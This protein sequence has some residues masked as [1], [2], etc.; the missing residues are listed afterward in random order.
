MSAS[1]SGSNTF[2][3]RALVLAWK[4]AYP[5]GSAVVMDDMTPDPHPIVNGTRGALENVDGAGQFH[6][7]WEG[8]RSLAAIPGA[9]KFRVKAA[10]GSKKESYRAPFMAVTF[11]RGA[12]PADYDSVGFILNED[13][14]PC[15]MDGCT[16]VRMRVLWPDGKVTFPCS[17]GCRL[18]E[19][20]DSVGRVY[21]IE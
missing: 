14:M 2:S 5:A 21:R 1:H 15:R 10:L 6:T 16:G 3:P 20:N 18:C 7:T 17:K 19:G 12:S 11:P 9:D 8:G 4:R 13:A